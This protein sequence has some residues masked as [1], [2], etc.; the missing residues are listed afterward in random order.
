MRVSS[1]YTTCCCSCLLLYE[2]YDVSGYRF[3][4]ILRLDKKQNDAALQITQPSNV[5]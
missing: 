2:C 1:R 5:V 3:D 4:P